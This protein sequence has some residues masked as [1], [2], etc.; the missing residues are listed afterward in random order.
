MSAKLSNLNELSKIL[1]QKETQVSHLYQ[2]P[3]KTD[4]QF[5]KTQ[6]NSYLIYIII[7]FNNI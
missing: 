3:I 7:L 5:Y 6:I 2:T 1:S 4:V